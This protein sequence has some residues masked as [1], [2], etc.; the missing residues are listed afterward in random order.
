MAYI[1]P[2]GYAFIEPESRFNDSGL[3]EI[4]KQYR[5]ARKAVARVKSWKPEY[6]FAC[7]CGAVQHS[8]GPCR[9]CQSRDKS[10]MISNSPT[11]PFGGKD[12]TGLRVV[13]VEAMVTQLTEDTHRLPIDCIIAVLGDDV[14]LDEAHDSGGIK[15][16]KYCGPAKEGTDNGMI[17]MPKDGKHICPRCKRD[18][19]GIV[20]SSY[21]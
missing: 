5:M 18:E 9:K 8:R 1:P 20:A 16:C 19:Y 17:L 2:P 15:R 4:P 14:V 7:S 3:I 12:I 11:D 21:P 6:R 10:R 13:Y